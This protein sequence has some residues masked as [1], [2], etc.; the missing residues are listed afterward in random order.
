MG[1]RR[2]LPGTHQREKAWPPK[3]HVR[4]SCAGVSMP[5]V[6]VVSS[7]GMRAVIRRAVIRRAVGVRQLAHGDAV[8]LPPHPR[9][10]TTKNRSMSDEQRM[11]TSALV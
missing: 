2:S 7:G 11:H 1:R 9:A 10:A 8:N 4:M 3:P 6:R 5:A